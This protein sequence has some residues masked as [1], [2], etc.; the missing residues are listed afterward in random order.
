MKRIIFYQNDNT[1][2]EGIKESVSDKT[3]IEVEWLNSASEIDISITLSDR[4]PA[5]FVT[6]LETI[7]LKSLSVRH[8]KSILDN[9]VH[10]ICC[11]KESEL[12]LVT[13]QTWIGDWL[14]TIVDQEL[15]QL[16]GQLLALTDELPEGQLL[17]GVSLSEQAEMR[18]PLFLQSYTYHGA[19]VESSVSLAPETKIKNNLPGI[20]DHFFS[21]FHSITGSLGLT[22]RSHLAFSHTLTFSYCENQIDK[23]QFEKFIDDGNYDLN[24]LKIPEEAFKLLDKILIPKKTSPLVATDDSTNGFDQDSDEK[25]IQLKNICRALAFGHTLTR[26]NFLDVISIY[27]SEMKGLETSSDLNFIVF[28][29]S[30]ITKP[31]EEILKDKPSIIVIEYNRENNFQMIKELVKATTQ[32]KDYFP[33]FVIFNYKEMEVEE[34]RDKLEYHFVIS[35]TFKIN[36]DLILKV[37]NIYRRKQFEKQQKRAERNFKELIEKN[38]SFI[39]FD[40]SRT[41]LPTVYCDPRSKQFYWRNSFPITI[42][43][44]GLLTVTIETQLKLNPGSIITIDSPANLQLFILKSDKSPQSYIGIIHLLTKEERS[45][46]I[47]FL[48]ELELLPDKDDASKNSKP[49]E[50]LKRKYYHLGR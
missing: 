2:A 18:F 15:A 31:S 11:L 50:A 33:Y 35:A 16:T 45:R 29:K 9:S 21:S 30:K 26:T 10:L 49:L 19:I 34:L 42:K 13:D 25:K 47:T 44:L 4:K 32:L 28:R 46:Y 8:L 3:R 17:S 22:T 14:Y 40:Q 6:D 37:L 1:V 39:T 20:I 36:D 41:H 43:R 24:E 23:D 27:Q 38:P 5:V 48:D 7:T 12:P